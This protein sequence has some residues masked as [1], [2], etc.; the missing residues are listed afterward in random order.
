VA[1]LTCNDDDIPLNKQWKPRVKYFDYLAQSTKLHAVKQVFPYV[2]AALLHLHDSGA[3]KGI[4]KRII[5]SDGGPGHFKVY[6][7]QYWMSKWCTQLSRDSGISTEWNMYFANLGHNICDS[8]AGHMKRQVRQNEGNFVHMFSIMD[9]IP[10][11]KKLKNTTSVELTYQDINEADE[12][13]VRAIGKNFIKKYHHFTYISPGVVGCR[14]I[15]GIGDLVMNRMSQ[16]GMKSCCGICSDDEDPIN[17]AGREWIECETCKQWFHWDCL[18]IVNE[19][20]NKVFDC[21]LCNIKKIAREA[22]KLQKKARKQGGSKKARKQGGS[23]KAR[24]QGGSKNGQKEIW[25]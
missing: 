4:I 15:K 11:M 14:Y 18:G 20:E 7:T 5:A 22:L 23:K 12:E 13:P 21:D 2:K 10:C 24:K 1:V 3:L 6:K 19:E 25:P 8:H 17:D 9:I 16:Q